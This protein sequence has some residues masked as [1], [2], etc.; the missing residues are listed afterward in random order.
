MAS[1]DYPI[2]LIAPRTTGLSSYF[3]NTISLSNDGSCL[4][5]GAAGEGRNGDGIPGGAAYL[6][7]RPDRG[8]RANMTTPAYL[9]NPNMGETRG[10]FGTKLQLSNDCSVLTV[11]A[12]ENN[13]DDVK[14]AAFVYQ[15]LN[16]GWSGTTNNDYTPTY[17]NQPSNSTATPYGL[18]YD[19]T[20]SGDGMTLAFATQYQWELG[21]VYVFQAPIGGWS[22]STNIEYNPLDLT[23]PNGDVGINVIGILSLSLSKDGS[24]LAIGAAREDGNFIGTAFETISARPSVLK[25]NTLKPIDNGVLRDGGAVYLY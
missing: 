1:N 7:Q 19:L 4:A 9:Q 10:G 25:G 14:G 13:P 22:D 5:I 17:L 2:H 24:T 21:H 16:S 18:G 15:R 11:G 23:I 6:Y 12:S 20:L 8:W 3:G